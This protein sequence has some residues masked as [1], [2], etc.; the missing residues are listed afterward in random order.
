MLR[1]ARQH[2]LDHELIEDGLTLLRRFE[3]LRID[4]IAIGPLELFE[5]LAHRAIEFLAADALTVDLGDRVDVALH[6]A[7]PLDASTGEREDQ[8]DQN[9][10][11]PALVFTNPFEHVRTT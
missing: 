10:L 4:G 5:L 8:R 7:I 2:I 11:S 9:D 1:L 6:A 3:H